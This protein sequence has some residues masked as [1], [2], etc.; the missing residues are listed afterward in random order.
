MKTNRDYKIGD[1]A[2]IVR[3]CPFWPSDAE[4]ALIESSGKQ[5]I[6]VAYEKE[7]EEVIPSLV[8]AVSFA[9]RAA[10]GDFWRRAEVFEARL[11]N[12]YADVLPDHLLKPS[13]RT[14]EPIEGGYECEI[15]R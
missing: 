11:V 3:H 6:D 9:R 13:A 5:V 12:P 2:Y 7:Q 15:Q 4:K 8:K 1:T 10:K 14:W